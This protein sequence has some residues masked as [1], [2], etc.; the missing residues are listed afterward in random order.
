SESILGGS[1]LSMLAVPLWRGD[2]V[3]GIIQADNRSSAGMFS[4]ND[5]EVGLLLAAQ[6]SLAIDN[7][8]LVQRLKIAEERL[9]GE[10]VYLRRRDQKIKFDNIIGDSA[11]MKAVFTQLERVIDTR[12]T[13]C[14]EGETGTGK[15][16]IA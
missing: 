5:L 14:I 4:E 6:A 12:A 1:I 10:N 9:R 13:V 3:I 11:A 16:L 15:E 2:D 8:T 7:A